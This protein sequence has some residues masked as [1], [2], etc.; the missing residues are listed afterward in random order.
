MSIE[1]ILSIV[2]EKEVKFIDYRFTNTSGKEQH[3][4]VTAT[5]DGIKTDFN[6]GKMFDGSSI[7]AWKDINESDMIL[8]PDASTAVMDPFYDEPTLAISCDV[9]EPTDGKPYEK[10]PRSIAKNAEAYLQSTGIADTAYF[11]PENEFFVFDDVKFEDKLG[12]CF[13]SVDSSEA[14]YNSGKAFDEGNMGHR[15]LVKGGYFPVPP[16]DALQDCRSAMVTTL[17]EMGVKCEVHHHE[18][19]TAGQCE[20]GTLFNTLV[21]KAD[22]VQKYKYV[23]MNVAHAYG[24]TATFM[25]KPLVGDN[26]S[27][28]HIHQS[29]AKGGKNIFAGDKYGNLS[30]EALWYIGGIIKHARAL[31][32]FANASTNSYKRLIPGFEAPV[33]LTYSA[34][35]RSAAIRIPYVMSDKA[36][37]IEVRFPDST[38]NPYLAFSAMMMAGLDGIANKINPGDPMDKDLFEISSDEEKML[39]TVAA[40]LDVALDALD[41]D[42]D[43]LKAGSVFTD[44]MIDAYIGLKYEDV[45][46]LRQSTHP[47]EFEMYYSL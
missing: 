35:N 43:F 17:Q 19:A 7:A 41:K 29:L 28:M 6:E 2:K 12:S 3:V 5:D 25:P 16:V 14:C 32:A 46:R 24:K 1:E 30:Q 11:G 36:R 4:T 42:R 18:V 9:I 45:Q 34:R 39:P 13:F 22:E 37:R 33:I 26:G 40:G 8:M 20:I 15:P 47:C 38:A 27:G 10:D 21:K 23:V 44:N 31:N